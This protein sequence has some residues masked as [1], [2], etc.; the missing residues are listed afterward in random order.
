MDNKW[1]K[2]L[3]AVI[4]GFLLGLC[5]MWGFDSYGGE[6][7]TY[8]DP[9]TGVKYFGDALP[10]SIPAN[11][12]VEVR[13]HECVSIVGNNWTATERNK[14]VILRVNTPK[15]VTKVETQPLHMQISNLP[16]SNSVYDELIYESERPIRP[17][18]SIYERD[19][20]RA[21]NAWGRYKDKMFDWRAKGY[22]MGLRSR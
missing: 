12:R 5:F 9:K 14:V 8:T 19:F 21:T 22:G 4:G 1:H 18:N 17:G 3:L 2:M 16:S 13:E 6:Y 15:P 20:N 7:M 11:A 10:P